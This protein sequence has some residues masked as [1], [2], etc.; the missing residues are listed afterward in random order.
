MDSEPEKK[1]KIKLLITGG[2]AMSSSDVGDAD[3][4]RFVSGKKGFHR[5]IL[6]QLSIAVIV[7]GGLNGSDILDLKR[8]VSEK[9]ADPAGA[10][11]QV[12]D[13]GIGE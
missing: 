1:R 5:N 11:I 2:I 12:F 7:H 8:R 4:K 9:T 3:V 6:G 10:C 13:D